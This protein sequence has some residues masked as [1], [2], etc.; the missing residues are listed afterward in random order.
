MTQVHRPSRRPCPVGVSAHP[1]ANTWREG[2]S[3]TLDPGQRSGGRGTRGGGP[4]TAY[5]SRL[6]H[7]ATRTLVRV[8]LCATVGT[9][10]T[11]LCAPTVWSAPTD[12]Y[13]VTAT[14]PVNGLAEGIAISPPDGSRAYVTHGDDGAAGQLS[15]ID[16]ATKTVLNTLAVG[17]FPPV[18]S[19][20]PPPTARPCTPAATGTTPSPS[21]TQPLSPSPQRSPPS[22]TAHS[23]SPSPLT[24]PRFSSPASST[25][26]SQSSTRQPTP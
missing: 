10:A 9:T 22:A 12:S 24:G 15:V 19:P 13:A 6:R 4:M 3:V 26:T 23:A 18:A 2:S 14:I 17:N 21:S 1:A 11:V 20:S 7:K 5:R 8:A 16:T 25:A